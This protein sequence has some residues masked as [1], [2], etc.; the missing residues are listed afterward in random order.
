VLIRPT[1]KFEY[2]LIGGKEIFKFKTDEKIE[3]FLPPQPHFLSPQTY[4]MS[5]HKLYL[6]DHSTIIVVDTTKLNKSLVKSFKNGFR[7]PY[8][9]YFSPDSIFENTKC[10][11]PEIL[12]E[13]RC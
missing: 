9:Y 2:I 4:A 12:Y 13:R 3:W 1:R 7:E 8:R 11:K 10:I 5:A 6:F